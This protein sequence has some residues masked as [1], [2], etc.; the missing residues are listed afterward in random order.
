MNYC[1]V[2]Y[3]VERLS[4]LPGHI[5][6]NG[7]ASTVKSAAEGPDGTMGFLASGCRGDFDLNVDKEH[8]T[9]T[10]IGTC[11]IGADRRGKI[12]PAMV[13]RETVYQGHPVTIGGHVWTIPVALAVFGRCGLPQ[14]RVLNAQGKGEW[15]LREA[16]RELC[17]RAR[18]VWEIRSGERPAQDLS[19][20]DLDDLA[21]AVMAVNYRIG[22]LD[23]LAME[24]ID[25]QSVRDLIDAVLDWPTLEA[26]LKKKATPD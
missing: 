10:P 18:V 17:D 12:T 20:D 26:V 3:F 5:L 7:R 8:Q 19:E 24:L 15:K 25:N 16:Y 9:W 13:E 6:E 2:M 14:T 23:L 22:K 1:P 11:W 21:G 4:D